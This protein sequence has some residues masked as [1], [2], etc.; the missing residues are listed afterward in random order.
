M[1]ACVRAR[2]R[3]MRP[4]TVRASPSLFPADLEGWTCSGER[5]FVNGASE[6]ASEMTFQILSD[7]QRRRLWGVAAGA[8]VILACGV[9]FD[10]LRVW[11]NLFVVAFYLTTLALGGALFLALA[12]VCGAGWHIAFRRIPEAMARSL[13]WPGLVL[14]ALLMTVATRYGWH[15]HGGGDARPI[16][17]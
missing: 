17:V 1:E 9:A 15:A 2:H 7:Q 6:K 10:P 12:S 13:P 11:S 14:F 4:G 5:E 8:G 16:L 3:R